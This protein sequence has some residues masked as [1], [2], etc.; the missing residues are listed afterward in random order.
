M[1]LVEVGFVLLQTFQAVGK[2]IFLL[3]LIIKKHYKDWGRKYEYSRKVSRQA[4]AA[5]ILK[6]ISAWSHSR[7]LQSTLEACGRCF[8]L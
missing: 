3:V 8:R 7:C 6:P 4:V 5:K 2:G 1:N